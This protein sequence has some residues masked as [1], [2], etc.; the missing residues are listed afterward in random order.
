MNSLIEFIR[1]ILFLTAGIG[2]FLYGMHMLSSHLERAL[3]T[4]LE[5]ALRR[6]TG[7]R[8]LGVL[9]GTAVT[10]LVQ[11]STAVTVM[12]V[13]FVD[14]G[15]MSLRQA[16]WVIL[17]ANIGTSVTSQLAALPV[18]SITLPLLIPGGVLLFWEKFGGK[19]RVRWVCIGGVLTGLG[20]LFLGMEMMQWAMVPFRE[21]PFFLWLLTDCRQPL[22]GIFGGA[23]FTALVQSSSASVAI[24][25]ALAENGMVSLEAAAYIVFGQN[26]GTCMTAMLAAAGSGLNAKRAALSHLLINVIGAVFFALLCGVTPL[27]RWMASWNADNPSMQVAN[28]HLV[29]N[30]VST[31]LLLPFGDVLVQEI[32]KIGGGKAQK[33]ALH[34]DKKAI[35][36]KKR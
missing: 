35:R 1:A 22:T 2:I 14:N 16:V 11:S 27:L 24:L 12:V 3:D 26:I 7:N 8:V 31:V 19:I 28:I 9:T 4:H 6:L 30:V 20:M 34:F 36:Y 10:A 23:A 17:G 32:E 29:F 13:G 5:T 21:S 33:S 25:Q 18:S 15:I